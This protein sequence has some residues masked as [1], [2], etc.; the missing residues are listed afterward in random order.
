MLGTNELSAYYSLYE[1]QNAHY[2]DASGEETRDVFDIRFAGDRNGFDWDT[3]AMVQLG[4]VGDKNIRAWALG[5]RF[6]YTL[7]DL[8]WTPRIGLQFDAASGDKAH[9][10]DTLGTF[11]PLFP[12]G[13]YFTLAGYTGYTNLIHFKPSIT[14]K[15]NDQLTATAALGLQWRQTTADAI[16][17]QPNQPIKGTAGKGSLWSGAYAQLRLDYAFTPNL[18]GAI[19]AVHYEIGSTIRAAGGKNG[20][21]LGVQLALAW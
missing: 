1:R 8:E 2:L 10:D 17:L 9:G 4:T 19:E 21:Y 3:E 18:T 12:N 6:G 11:N 13:Y 5:T 20:N 14:F 16:Y 15:P 7:D